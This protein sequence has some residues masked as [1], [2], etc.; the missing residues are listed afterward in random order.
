MKILITSEAYFFQTIGAAGVVKNLVE[1]LRNMGHSVKVLS[2]SN[3]TRS[4]KKN[5][6]Y[7]I[8]S[9]LSFYYHDMCEFAEGAE[10]LLN[11]AELNEGMRKHSLKISERFSA[12]NNAKLTL[13]V[14]KQ[15][16]Q[17]RS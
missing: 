13:E 11:D 15:V 14:Y 3:D 5:D 7:L 9:Y 2:L 17:R 10:R 8:G 4:W 6:D 1:Q 12:E 16:I